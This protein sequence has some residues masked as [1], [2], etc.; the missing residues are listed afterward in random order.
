MFNSWKS[1]EPRP[2]VSHLAMWTILAFLVGVPS[3]LELIAL[4]RGAG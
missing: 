2:L 4:A 3:V 1:Y